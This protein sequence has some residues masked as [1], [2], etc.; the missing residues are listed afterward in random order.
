MIKKKNNKKNNR[1]CPAFSQVETKSAP[2][3]SQEPP[4][5]TAISSSQL[6]ISWGPPRFPNGQSS[7]SLSVFLFLFLFLEWYK[8]KSTQNSASFLCTL[9]ILVIIFIYI[10]VYLLYFCQSLLTPLI[11]NLI[12]IKDQT[13]I[14]LPQGRNTV[15]ELWFRKKRLKKKKGKIIFLTGLYYCYF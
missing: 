9:N 2:P 8:G 4:V 5:I 12:K 13:M 6:N 3:E 1:P 7:V 15:Y 11:Y 10:C 14:S